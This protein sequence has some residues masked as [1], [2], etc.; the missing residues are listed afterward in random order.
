MKCPDELKERYRERRLIP[1]IGAGVS[2]SVR[3]KDG[4]EER[5]G[6]SWDELVNYVATKLNFRPDLIRMRGRDL[7]ILEYYKIKNGGNFYPFKNWLVQRLNPPD[8]ALKK[9]A[10]HKALAKMT[11]CETFYTTNFDNFLEQSFLLNGRKCKA[12]VTEADMSKEAD[13]CHIVKF[14]GDLDHPGDMVISETQYEDRLR[15]A[16]DL[17]CRF[18]ADT[19]SNAFLFMGYS[20]RD[21]NV[22]Y[23]FTTMA[24][25]RGKLPHSASGTRA[26]ITVADPSDFERELFKERHMEIIPIRGSNMSEDIASLLKQIAS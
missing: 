1:F 14:H 16:S 7:Q 17:D 11:G 22:S 4:K 15:L 12:V 10:I 19:L 25:E 26:Y 20:F 3:W 6:P 8:N 18:K 23:I 13:V 21:P 24:K 9:S 5:S 2:M